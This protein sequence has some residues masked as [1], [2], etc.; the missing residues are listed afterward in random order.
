[1]TDPW[2]KNG[3]YLNTSGVDNM[4]Y[5]FYVEDG[6]SALKSLGNIGNWDTSEV[7]DMTGMFYVNGGSSA[8]EDLE[9]IGNWDTSRVTDMSQMF[10]V[11]GESS[12]KSLGNINKW[13]T[14]GVKTMANMFAN[15]DNLAVP[16]DYFTQAGTHWDTTGVMVSTDFAT[17]T[18]DPSTLCVAMDQS[19]LFEPPNE[20]GC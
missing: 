5:M 18:G 15:N 13:D 14:S 3:T 9:N 10:L 16:V 7:T 20:W 12:L 2:S 1:M 19:G 6:D 17:D 8:L 4:S 11:V